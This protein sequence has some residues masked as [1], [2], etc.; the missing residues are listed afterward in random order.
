MAKR[1]ILV[2]EADGDW[3]KTDT[4]LR[5]LLRRD[6]VSILNRYG[7]LGVEKLIA[8][9]PKDTGL[10]AISW[11]YRVDKTKTGYRLIWTN[12]NL[13]DGIPVAMLIQ[14]GHGTRGGTFVEGIDYINP[15]LRPIFDGIA[16]DLWK[17]VT[18]A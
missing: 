2:F 7:K 3:K 17:E 5:K 1:A 10:T 8:W 6:T 11:S 12:S 4:F 16:E 15:A 13:S 14:Y 9:T 18:K